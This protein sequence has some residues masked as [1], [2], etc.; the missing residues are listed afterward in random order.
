[1]LNIKLFLK[2]LKSLT[3]ARTTQYRLGDSIPLQSR[4]FEI[5]CRDHANVLVRLAKNCTKFQAELI[6]SIA[7]H[8]NNK[9]LHLAQQT[10]DDLDSGTK[11]LIPSHIINF[12]SRYS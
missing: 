2:S 11:S 9:N 12:I 7:R 10:I 8:V 3:E 5:N 1:M 6:K 4:Q